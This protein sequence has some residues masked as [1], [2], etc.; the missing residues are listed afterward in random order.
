MIVSP[1]IQS[2]R[3]N[4]SVA[5]VF[6]ESLAEDTPRAVPAENTRSNP[7]SGKYASMESPV[8]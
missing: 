8:R 5:G 6:R 4:S 7:P 2:S 1:E 3:R